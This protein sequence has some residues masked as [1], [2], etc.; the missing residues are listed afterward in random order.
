MKV[1]S[2]L[3][4]RLEGYAREQLSQGKGTMS[5]VHELVR[6]AHIGI[7]DART[8]VEH[9]RPS[10]MREGPRRGRRTFLYGLLIL[11]IP[12]SIVGML[13][14]GEVISSGGTKVADAL[15]M[16]IYPPMLLFEVIGI[17][18]VAY[19]WSIMR[20]SKGSIDPANPMG[21]VSTGLWWRADPF[22]W[23]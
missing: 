5:I 6:M 23:K 12:L 19:G 2:D 14:Y 18:L 11:A 22:E 10:V 16:L 17:A 21:P 1:M 3:N 8:I 4:L 20:H 9:T 15:M 13:L 7:E